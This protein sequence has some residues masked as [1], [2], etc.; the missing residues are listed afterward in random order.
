MRVQVKAFG[1]LTDILEKEFYMTAVD[2]E[3]LLTVLSHQHVALAHRKLLIAVNNRIIND[4]VVLQE[5]DIVALMP[6]YSGG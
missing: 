1:A 6:P 2:T 3:E 4:P 5:N